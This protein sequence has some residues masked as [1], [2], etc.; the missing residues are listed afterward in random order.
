[1]QNVPRRGEKREAGEIG[2][3][4]VKVNVDDMA[5]SE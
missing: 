5:G 1:M 2:V 4:K 3:D